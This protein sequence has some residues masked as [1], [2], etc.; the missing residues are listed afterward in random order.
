MCKR[1]VHCHAAAPTIVDHQG[2]GRIGQGAGVIEHRSYPAAQDIAGIVRPA[3]KCADK[4]RRSLEAAAGRHSSAIGTWA[5]IESRLTAQRC[6]A[7]LER[8]SGASA[9]LDADVPAAPILG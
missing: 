9:E 7:A 1:F 2:I 6:D 4:N 8:D 5:W 3:A